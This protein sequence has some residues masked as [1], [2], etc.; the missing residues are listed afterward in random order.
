MAQLKSET[1]FGS[2]LILF[3]ITRIEIVESDI[4]ED[5]APRL[6]LVL[7]VNT[8]NIVTRTLKASLQP[9]NN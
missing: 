1:I 6:V 9:F 4:N 7:N 8:I 2:V 5:I 3:V